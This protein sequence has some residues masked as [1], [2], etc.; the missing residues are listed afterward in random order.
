MDVTV[1]A[2]DASSTAAANAGIDQ[3][4]NE[5]DLTTLDGTA[6]EGTNLS[7]SWEQLS[8]TAVT[9]SSTDTAQ[10]VFTAPQV[11]AP[12]TLRF[13]LT[14]QDGDGNSDTD[15]VDITVLDSGP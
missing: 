5:G 7:Y 1:L 3:Q 11:D 10:P 6:S 15:E 14:V 8:G 12:E 9:L 2:G 4:V 13:R